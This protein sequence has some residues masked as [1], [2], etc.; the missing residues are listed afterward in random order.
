MF[1]GGGKAYN[2]DGARVYE[3][4]SPKTGDITAGAVRDKFNTS[5]KYAI[6]LLEHLDALKVTRRVG[7]SRVLR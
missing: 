7:D 2:R 6:A 3:S 5:R 4:C 1:A